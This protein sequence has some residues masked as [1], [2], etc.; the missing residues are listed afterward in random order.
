MTKASESRRKMQRGRVV[1]ERDEDPERKKE[2]EEH[3]RKCVFTQRG[4]VGDSLFEIAV[5]LQHTRRLYLYLIQTLTQYVLAQCGFPIRM[6]W[7]LFLSTVLLHTCLQVANNIFFNFSGFDASVSI[8]DCR[9]RTVNH[10][11]F[12]IVYF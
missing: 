6:V 2:N 3:N 12:N 9:L 1:I 4:Y 8:G 11:S 10:Q 7:Y 5:F